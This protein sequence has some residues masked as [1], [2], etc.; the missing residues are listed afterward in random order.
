MWAKY[1]KP[2][3][4]MAANG[5]LAGLVAITAPCAF[6]NSVGAFIIG[7]VA[8]VLVCVAVLF[9]DQKLNIDDPVGA[10][11]VHGV[12]GIWGVLSL[13]LFA[14][15]T[16]GDGWN[17]VNGTVTGLFYGDASQFFAQCVGSL[18]CILFVFAMFYAFFKVCD[19]IWGIRVAEETELEG[20]D[21]PEV[22]AL[23][24]PEFSIIPTHGFGGG[25]SGS[26]GSGGARLAPAPAIRARLEEA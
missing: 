12:N 5:L 1:G 19:V 17:G 7:A 26:G 18:T 13:G 23:A 24:Y 9:I 20:L 10:I 16:Y 11:S 14:D 2:D 22:G 21:I 4:S 15:G 25:S 3:P 6:V 8:G